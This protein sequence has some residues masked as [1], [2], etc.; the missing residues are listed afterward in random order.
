M[1]KSL[2]YKTCPKCKGRQTKII[3][4]S[5]DE[6]KAIECQVCGHLYSFPKKDK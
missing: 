4:L 1:A 3:H 2:S 6:D 5:N